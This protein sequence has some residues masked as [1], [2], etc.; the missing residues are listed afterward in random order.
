MRFASPWILIVGLIILAGIYWYIN[1]FKRTDYQ[2][3]LKFSRLWLMN[4]DQNSWKVLGL[5][6]LKWSKYLALILLL[7]AL[8]RPQ[9]GKMFDIS[10]DQGIDIMIAL[11]T[12]SSME[13]IDF[14]PNRLEAAKTVTVNF[15]EARKYDKIG[16]VNFSGLAF[17]QSPLTTDKASLIDFVK[18]INIGDT[19]L[20]GTAIGS[21]II[22][23]VNRL[24]NSKAK[25]KVIVLITD[26]NNNRGEIDPLTASQIAAQYDIK[27]YAIG[28]G[29]PE[30]G[31]HV[32]NDPFFGRREVRTPEDKIN[33][34]PLKQIAANTDGQYFRA[35]DMRSFENIMKQ[36]DGLE[37]DDIKVTQFTTYN[38]LY[39]SFVWIA[40]IILLLTVL[41]E[42]TIL[43]KLP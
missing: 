15:I 34:A 39:K 41:L 1:Y 33:E 30:G 43:R 29:S 28:V 24:K 22:T 40:F 10:N 18:G 6:I 17:T 9:K 21:A 14:K 27:I 11:D 4:K 31:I 35:L 38:E 12:S 42:N 7:I 25:S 19:G 13:S 37:K 3:A 32:I 20:D 2:A 8:A 16:L 23:C 26:G 5:K 36:I